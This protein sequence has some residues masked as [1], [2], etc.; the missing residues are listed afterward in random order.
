MTREV[1]FCLLAAALSGGFA[2]ACWLTK[3]LLLGG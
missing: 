1:R 2:A 3:T